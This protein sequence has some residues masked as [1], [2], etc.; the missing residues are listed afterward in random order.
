MVLNRGGSVLHTCMGFV[1]GFFGF[2]TVFFLGDL[3]LLR[4]EKYILSLIIVYSLFNIYI[5]SLVGHEFIYKT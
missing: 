2:P 1:V 3:L 5:I 4:G